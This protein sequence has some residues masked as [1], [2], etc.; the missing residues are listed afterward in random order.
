MESINSLTREDLQSFHETWIRPSN[1]TLFVVG[2]TT[3][4]EILP[5]LENA[6]GSWPENR[7]AIPEKNLAVVAQAERQ[8]LSGTVASFG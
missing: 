7:R 6:F 2:D 4:T 1:G 3:M 5:Q 8:Q